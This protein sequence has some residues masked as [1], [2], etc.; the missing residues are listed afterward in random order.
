[1]VKVLATVLEGKTVVVMVGE[2]E[3][4]LEKVFVR[5]LVG[6]LV[7]VLVGNRVKVPVGV[8]VNE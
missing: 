3:G 7:P 8:G 1:M 4:V 5:V 6:V 2:L